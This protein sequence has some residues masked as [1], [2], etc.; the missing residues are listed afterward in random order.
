LSFATIFGGLLSWAD[1]P[2][3]HREQKRHDTARELPRIGGGIGWQEWVV[4][5]EGFA[6]L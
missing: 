2:A 1:H 5:Q 3:E 6:V 4:H